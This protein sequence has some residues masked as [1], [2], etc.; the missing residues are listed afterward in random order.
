MF[1]EF[2]LFRIYH[3][4]LA[5]L[6]LSLFFHSCARAKSFPQS[7]SKVCQYPA[8][9]HATHR[10]LNGDEVQLNCLRRPLSWVNLSLWFVTQC[11]KTA[12]TSRALCD[13]PY[14]QTKQDFFKWHGYRITS[15]YSVC[16]F[17]RARG[18]GGR[19]PVL[20]WRTP[21]LAPTSESLT[22]V[23]SIW[24]RELGPRAGRD[25]GSDC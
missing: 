13:S 6:D 18:T 25:E 24:W 11:S 3:Q 12:P 14:G 20:L 5:R 4:V 1:W 16:E 8:P 10:Q 2:S 17:G 9:L 23:I 21:G 19:S 15:L 22:L 7:P